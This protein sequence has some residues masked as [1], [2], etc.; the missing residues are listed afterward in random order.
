MLTAGKSTNRI[1]LILRHRTRYL[2]Q[3]N[4][5]SYDRFSE[6]RR[7]DQ[8]GR[9]A[10]E[11]HP[12][13]DGRIPF[14]TFID[15][16]EVRSDI[17]EAHQLTLKNDGVHQNQMFAS[18]AILLL[19]RVRQHRKTQSLGAAIA[20]VIGKWSAIRSEDACRFDVRRAF[21]RGK[22]SRGGLGIV[23]Q[24]S[25]HAIRAHNLGLR[26]KSIHQ[27]L[28][29]RDLVIGEEGG[30]RE[31]Q[32]G[33]AHQH[34]HPRYFCGDGLG[35]GSH[36]PCS[37]AWFEPM[38]LTATFSSSELTVFPASPMAATLTSNRILPSWLTSS[39]MPPR[40]AN[41]G[42]SLT[43]SEF[44]WRAAANMDLSRLSSEELTNRILQCAASGRF[45]RFLTTIFFPSTVSP[46]TVA[47]SAEL[48]GFLP[49]TQMAN[50]PEPDAE[51]CQR[52]NLPKL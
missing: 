25:S 30:S 12:K 23:E 47:A 13:S 18:K 44:D 16:S 17:Y 31:Q 43:V 2:G 14:Q 15:L 35:S 7:D 28:P 21:Q 22:S 6:Q 1:V 20:H 39:I 41:P 24:Q 50:E 38:I 45:A 42:M 26:G 49:S 32:C 48:K 9:Q 5:R 52:T 34:V 11:Q 46:D 33:A 3:R 10:Q 36:F 40:S 19:M 51:P 37:R 27:P 4:D 8:R 29:E